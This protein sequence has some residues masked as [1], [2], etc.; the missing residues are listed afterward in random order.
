MAAINSF[1]MS[2]LMSL[3]MCIINLGT[4]SLFWHAWPKSFAI[5]LLVAFPL[6]YFLPPLVQKMMKGK[7]HTDNR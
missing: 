1:F 3:I 7:P 6:S 2:F 4:G 5:A